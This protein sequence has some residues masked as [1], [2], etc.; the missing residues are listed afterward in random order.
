MYFPMHTDPASHPAC[1]N[2][3]HVPI[4]VKGIEVQYLGENQRFYGCLLS[5]IGDTPASALAGGFKEGVGGAYRG[6]RTCMIT[7]EQLS[8]K[9]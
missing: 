3:L 1:L 5:F 8:S 6:C 4:S 2:V 9:V 7:S